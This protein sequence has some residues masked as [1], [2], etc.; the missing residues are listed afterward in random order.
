MNTSAFM[1]ARTVRSLTV[2]PPSPQTMS[3][4]PSDN[5]SGMPSQPGKSKLFQVNR[6]ERPSR[7]G[8][9][10][11]TTVGVVYP[12]PAILMPRYAN[13]VASSSVTSYLRGA[14]SSG[15]AAHADENSMVS[16]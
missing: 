1:S 6:A 11:P 14:A 12:P 7:L 3:A 16:A 8:H 13:G 15:T 4:R 2:L 5:G 10:S 9:R